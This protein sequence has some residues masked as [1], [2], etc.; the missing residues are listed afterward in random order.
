M[1]LSFISESWHNKP[2]ASVGLS[3]SVCGPSV[4]GVSPLAL[5]GSCSGF[6]ANGAPWI[7]RGARRWE[8][9]LWLKSS[10][11]PLWLLNTDFCYLENYFLSRGSRTFVLVGYTALRCTIT[12]MQAHFP[13]AVFC[14]V[15]VTF[16]QKLNICRCVTLK[17]VDL[18]PDISCRKHRTC[19][20]QNRFLHC[21]NVELFFGL[22]VLSPI[23]KSAAEPLWPQVAP[24]PF[25]SCVALM[26]P[27][28]LKQ[29]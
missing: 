8:K 21:S 10:G 3:V 15:N 13:A 28:T 11:F 27:A 6:S 14:T 2:T 16:P 9:S 29:A 20:N 18:F 7:G 17:L 26:T 23:L 1:L 5:V 4:C 12:R 22:V 19:T 25:S 24:R